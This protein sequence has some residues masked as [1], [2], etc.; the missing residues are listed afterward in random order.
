MT[1]PNVTELNLTEF[2][3]FSEWMDPNPWYRLHT[4]SVMN[5]WKQFRLVRMFGR[6]QGDEN[7]VKTLKILWTSRKMKRKTIPRNVSLSMNHS[8][9]MN[10]RCNFVILKTKLKSL[11]TLMKPIPKF[12]W[13]EFPFSSWIK[14]ISCCRVW[15]TKCTKIIESCVKLIIRFKLV[16]KNLIK[17]SSFNLVSFWYSKVLFR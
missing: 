8:K 13:E 16:D 6:F 14:S 5:W 1:K 4:R 7:L 15:R 10:L 17:S 11:S 12:F 2:N 3:L 9:I